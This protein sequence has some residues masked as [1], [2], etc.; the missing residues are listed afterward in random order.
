MKNKNVQEIKEKIDFH[1]DFFYYNRVKRNIRKYRRQAGYTQQE[2][3]EL[4]D[5]SGNFITQVESLSSS[6]FL[7]IAT[8]GRISDA[9]NIDISKFFE[10]TDYI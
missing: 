2:L 7:T 4:V 5:V 10:P 9:L 6:K 1:D 3:A 8:L